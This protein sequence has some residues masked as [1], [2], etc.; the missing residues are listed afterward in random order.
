MLKKKLN[1]GNMESMEDIINSLNEVGFDIVRKP[2]IYSF[3]DYDEC[4]QLFESA[5][6]AVDATVR[7][8]VFLPEYESIVKW[9]T[10]TDGKGLFIT[11]N[12]GLGKSIIIKGVIPLIFK[13]KYNILVRPFS[14]A[15]IN[16]RER[17]ITQK[18]FIC[19]DDIGIEP[20]RNLY[21]E[22]S[23]VFCN[24]LD[25]AESKL[26]PLFVSSNMTS[27][28]VLNRYGDRALDRIVRLCHIVKINRSAGSLRPV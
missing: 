3:G 19:I 21:G 12:C 6:R 1:L 13:Y 27:K 9:M 22:K 10:N 11:G 26:K 28:D 2:N 24:I 15:D 14:A 5:F 7:N 16:E 8:F 20:T 17:E 23:E 18:P 4:R 25:N